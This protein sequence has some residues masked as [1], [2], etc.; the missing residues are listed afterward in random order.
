MSWC[1]EDET[2]NKDSKS[3]LQLLKKTTAIVP[4]IWNLEVTNVLVSAERRS[5]ITQEQTAQFIDLVSTLPIESDVGLNTVL[6]KEVL[7]LSR[8]Y[9]LSAYDAAYL[10]LA[11]RYKIPLATFDRNLRSCA[12][13]AGVKLL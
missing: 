8:K 7:K 6:N 13:A 11:L 9:N 1:F 10:E 2:I 3:L 4:A 12:T 5:R